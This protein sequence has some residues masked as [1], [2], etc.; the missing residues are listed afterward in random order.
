[1]ETLQL[2]DGFEPYYADREGEAKG[3]RLSSAGKVK[4]KLGEES[5]DGTLRR[6]PSRFDK[7]EGAFRSVDKRFFAVLTHP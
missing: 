7:A 1:M 5:G 3:G 6:N 2:Q 4:A